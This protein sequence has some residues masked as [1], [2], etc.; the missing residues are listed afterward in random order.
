M[1]D[2]TEYAFS[3][4][5]NSVSTN[6]LNLLKNLLFKVAECSKSHIQEE[7]WA[8]VE[9]YRNHER[10]EHSSIFLEKHLLHSGDIHYE[11]IYAT[12]TSSLLIQTENNTVHY[13]E[14]IYDHNHL[15]ERNEDEELAEKLLLDFEHSH[16]S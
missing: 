12:I 2:L 1:K 10:Y 14:R 6:D 5:D 3:V 9:S 16:L 15:R 7:K 11:D 8:K 13:Y 4:Y